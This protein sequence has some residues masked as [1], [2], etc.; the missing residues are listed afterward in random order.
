MASP[1]FGVIG[2]A[3][4][5]ENLALNLMDHGTPVAVWNLEYEWTERFVAAHPDATAT[6]TLEELV[7]AL[8]RPRRML[9]MIKAGAP[10][11]L[12][13][14]KLAPLCEPGDI[15]IDGGNS[16]FKDTQR[17]EAEWRALG[18]NFVGMGVSGGA[19]GARNGPSMMPGGSPEA[20]K[21]LEPALTSIAAKTSFG[22]CV[23]YVGPDGAGHFVKMVHNGIEYADMQLIAEVYDV[24]R[25]ALRWDAA[26]IADTFERWNQGPLDSYL[27]ELSARVLR[28]LDGKSATS[29]VDKVLDV[30][31]QKGTGK[32][33]AQVALDLGV[34]IPTINAAIDARLISTL[35]TER[36]AAATLYPTP[37]GQPI[38]ASL[39]DKIP[40]ALYAAKLCSYA[41]GMA[42]IAAGS[43]EWKWSIDLKE[44]A[45]IWTG[46]CI[47]RARLLEDVMR[48]FGRR[49]ELPNLLVDEDVRRAVDAG[50]A[51]L[52]ALVNAA[53]AA[54]V[55]VPALSATLAYFD[56]Y[57]TAELPTN[58]IQAQRDAF[59]AHTY[60]RNDVADA[61]FVH[62][63]WL[64]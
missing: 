37:A 48:A 36:D 31:G 52:R 47:I 34:P 45:R 63:E 7:R 32:W 17:R 11:D 50:Q 6:R 35:K 24:L 60:Q 55:P 12:T 30:A 44:M 28:V 20:W 14:A 10:V 53:Q 23:A 58:L 19:E 43:R 38:D 59:G 33:S 57:R 39:L 15:V 41:Q 56:S 3:V 18:L 9:M 8:P 29:L 40:P 26:K 1:T 46:G 51:S 21:A 22:A 49:P 5:G 61:P 4:M 2:L 25:R 54:A 27:L 13:M 42:L 64:K 62:T 16:W